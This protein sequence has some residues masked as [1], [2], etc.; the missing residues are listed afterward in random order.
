LDK[1]EAIIDCGKKT[2]LIKDPSRSNNKFFKVE[3]LEIVEENLKDGEAVI[4]ETQKGELE[5]LLVEDAS[6]TDRSQG[7]P[8]YLSSQSKLK[9]QPRTAKFIGLKSATKQS[10]N[11]SHPRNVREMSTASQSFRQRTRSYRTPWSSSDL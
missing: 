9:I 2:L 5:I 10:E 3:L 4:Q 6:D 7:I 8:V 1:T 11:K